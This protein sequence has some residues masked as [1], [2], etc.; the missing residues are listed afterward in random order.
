[1]CL[2]LGIAQAV[3]RPVGKSPDR[4]EDHLRLMEIARDTGVYRAA[5]GVEGRDAEPEQAGSLAGASHQRM[6]D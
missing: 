2:V 4:V 6:A 1:M 5:I 3:Q